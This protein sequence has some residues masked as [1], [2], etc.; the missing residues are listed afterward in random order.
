MSE[1]VKK[2]HDEGKLENLK[3]LLNLLSLEIDL[4]RWD[5]KGWIRIIDK[6]VPKMQVGILFKEDTY[7]ECVIQ[8][9]NYLRSSGEIRFKVAV[10]SLFSLD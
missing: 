7:E 5:E 10:N 3:E 9:G 1:G 6:Q 2:S 4:D 8:I